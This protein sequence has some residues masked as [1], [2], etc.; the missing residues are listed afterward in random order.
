MLIFRV[1]L[2]EGQRDRNLVY[3]FLIRIPIRRRRQRYS[4]FVLINIMRNPSLH[5]CAAR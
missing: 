5:Q 4:S 1:F 2:N 3:I